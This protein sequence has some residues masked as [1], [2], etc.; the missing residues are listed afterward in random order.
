LVSEEI[1]RGQEESKCFGQNRRGF[2]LI[3]EMFIKNQKLA[4]GVYVP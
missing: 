4:R 1:T 2:L 3:V